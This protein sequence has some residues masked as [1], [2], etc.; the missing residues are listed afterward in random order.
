MWNLLTRHGQKRISIRSLLTMLFVF[1]S[2]VPTLL[3]S[4]S[5]YRQSADT[6]RERI[7][8]YSTQIVELSQESL[9]SKF[10]DI[11]TYSIETAYSDRVQEYMSKSGVISDWRRSQ[12]LTSI[13]QDSG[14]KIS[15]Q[16]EDF[17]VAVI[18][19]SQSQ[20]IIYGNYGLPF[21]LKIMAQQQLYDM[22]VEAD[23]R[24][25]LLPADEEMHQHNI[26]YENIRATDNARAV[27]LARSIKTL[28]RGEVVGVLMI[29]ISERFINQMT[30]N[31]DLGDGSVS[32][33]TDKNGLVFASNSDFISLNQ[34]VDSN[35]TSVLLSAAS[36]RRPAE[37]RGDH[38]WRDGDRNYLVYSQQIPEYGLY[39]TG[40]IPEEYIN[41]ELNETSIRI[42]FL[43]ILLVAVMVLLSYLFAYAISNPLQKVINGMHE[44][45]RGNLGVAVSVSALSEVEEVS[46]N[47]NEMMD[48]IN[49]LVFN[50]KDK[51]KQKRVAELKALQAQINPHFL[52]NTLNTARWMASLQGNHNVDDLISSLIQLIN[53]TIGAKN[54]MIT[55]EEEL[56]NIRCFLRI[57]E[58]RYFDKFKASFDIDPQILKCRIPRLL[59]QPLVE[60]ALVHGIAMLEGQG[61]LAIKGLIENEQVRL[62]VTDNGAGMN[63]DRLHDVESGQVISAFNGIGISNV[64]ERIK[65]NFGEDY[66]L[67]I[68]SVP[69]L[70]T[71]CEIRIPKIIDSEKGDNDDVKSNAD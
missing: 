15:R 34:S 58:Y 41:S 18:H 70:Y 44:A 22:A 69:D 6:M 67:T 42:T 19:P 55:I 54:D 1:V 23:G 20:T 48:E 68:K 2:V 10:A 62:L 71:T 29:R 50:V 7:S 40:M 38:I 16:N 11:E 30:Q 24:T 66:G 27:M 46:T 4:L 17:V 33:L 61:T 9:A 25:V 47:F 32:F 31:V 26:W 39:F 51:E 35:L 28:Y 56:E 64:R 3:A 60:N 13:R 14:I 59:L 43:M 37:E 53:A 8:S 57:Q 45:R 65:L 49:N 5:F 52:A 12:L 36:D 21:S 63:T